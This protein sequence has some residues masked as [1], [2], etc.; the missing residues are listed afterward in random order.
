MDL[1]AADAALEPLHPPPPAAS[2]TQVCPTEEGRGG[3]RARR[4]RHPHPT[5]GPAAGPVDVALARLHAA[6]TAGTALDTEIDQAARA[7]LDA[8]ARYADVGHPLGSKKS[9]SQE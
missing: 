3:R 8:G 4:P 7:A 9:D 1:A 2:T 6:H 5:P